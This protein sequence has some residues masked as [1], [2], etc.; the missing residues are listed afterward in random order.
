MVVTPIKS[1]TTKVIDVLPD[2]DMFSSIEVVAKFTCPEITNN[3]TFYTD[4][5]GLDMMQR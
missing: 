1:D 4:S 2:Y 5:N 3:G